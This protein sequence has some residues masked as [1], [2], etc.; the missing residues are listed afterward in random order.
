MENQSY[1]QRSRTLFA[2]L[3]IALV[4]ASAIVAQTPSPTPE[5]RDIGLQPNQAANSQSNQAKPKE[6]KPELVLQTGYNSFFGATRLGFSPDGRLLATATFH[7]NTIKLWETAT[8]RELRNLSTGGQNTTSL[9]PVFAFS[10]DSRLLATSGGNNSVS[11]WDVTTGREVQTL[12]GTAGSFMGAFGVTFVGFS[13]DGRKLV[14]IS[15]SIRVWD[16]MTWREA[17]TIQT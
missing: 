13:G 12:N 11:V 10:P 17:S 14:T 1:I 15:D 9:S 16:T 7:T 2:C 3:I 8:G 5:K 4:S 6:P